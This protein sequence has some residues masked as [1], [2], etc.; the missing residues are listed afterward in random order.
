MWDYIC[1]AALKNSQENSPITHE[2][3]R[4][5][6]DNCDLLFKIIRMENHD[7][8]PTGEEDHYVVENVLATRTIIWSLELYQ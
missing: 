7:Y 3:Q 4:P 1:R 5:M 8:Y 6:N 2:K